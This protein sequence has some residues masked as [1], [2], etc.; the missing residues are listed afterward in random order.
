MICMG[1]YHHMHFCKALYRVRS[2]SFKYCRGKAN[3][4]HEVTVERK[5]RHGHCMDTDCERQYIAL[6]KLMK[7]NVHNGFWSCIKQS[8]VF[9]PLLAK[10]K[11][12][13]NADRS[14]VY[15]TVDSIG[16]KSLTWKVQVPGEKA[17]MQNTVINTSIKSCFVQL[18]PTA[19]SI[20][21]LE[22]PAAVG[23]FLAFRSDFLKAR[24]HSTGLS[25]CWVIGIN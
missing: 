18:S 3:N 24:N 13:G 21:E 22:M 9:R 10:S 1:P 2:R 7:L 15:C 12:W 20:N 11:T 6:L 16:T 23:G 5:T 8:H 19:P 4:S 25:N 17:A 14:C